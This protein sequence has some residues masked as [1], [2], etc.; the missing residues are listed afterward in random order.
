MKTDED[1]SDNRLLW[2][3]GETKRLQCHL[4]PCSKAHIPVAPV[5]LSTFAVAVAKYKLNRIVK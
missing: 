5:F 3:V 2:K 4:N 1:E